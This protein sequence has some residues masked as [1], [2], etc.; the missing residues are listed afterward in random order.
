M[1]SHNGEIGNPY[2][3]KREGKF[4]EAL[5]TYADEFVQAHCVGDEFIAR[6]CFDQMID[7]KLLDLLSRNRRFGSLSDLKREV[8]F[9]L[10]DAVRE[11]K[12][13]DGRF[14]EYFEISWGKF[15]RRKNARPLMSVRKE[16]L[17]GSGS[18]NDNYIR[19]FDFE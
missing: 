5:Q 19:N 13:L 14:Q 6:V 4:T 7:V 12:R 18:G 15:D 3:L 11:P 16:Q 2:I 8:I 10:K 9:H 17:V 1:N